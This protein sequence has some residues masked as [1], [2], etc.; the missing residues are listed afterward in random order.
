[1]TGVET[2]NELGLDF[3]VDSKKECFRGKKSLINRLDSL[4]NVLVGVE[5]NGHHKF[6]EEI[7]LYFKK[8]PVGKV[9]CLV[10]STWLNKTIGFA[11]IN[12]AF[13]HFGVFWRRLPTHN[14]KKIGAIQDFI[15][16]FL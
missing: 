16:V 15:Q 10:F 1:M 7:T 11:H 8:S 13:A 6:Y 4:D 12:P 3:V 2:P 5:T 14:P 9:K